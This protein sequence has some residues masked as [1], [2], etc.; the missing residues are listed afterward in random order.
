[1]PAPAGIPAL[2]AAFGKAADAW[3]AVEFVTMGPVSLSLRPG[4]FNFFPDRRNA[5]QRGMA[6]VLADPDASRFEPERFRRSSAATQGLPALERLLFDEGAADAL[7]SG[8]ETARRCI[9][10]SA[11]ALNLATIAKE[12]RE[13]WGDKT[14]GALGAIVSGKGDPALFPDVG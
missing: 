8:A 1:R 13:G 10:G 4:R 3:S 6:E 2:K 5:I 12:V 9:Y 11:I 7:A 14:S